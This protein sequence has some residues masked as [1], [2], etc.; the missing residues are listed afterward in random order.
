MNRKLSFELF[1]RIAHSLVQALVI[2][3]I[4]ISDVYFF[5]IF[6]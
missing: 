5:S 1:P 6:L 3:M 2:Y 4:F